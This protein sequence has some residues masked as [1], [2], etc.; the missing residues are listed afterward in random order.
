VAVGQCAGRGGVVL[1]RL[2]GMTSPARV[3]DVRRRAGWLPEQE[4]LEVWL[5][6]HRERV[7]ADERVV[8]HPVLVECQQL[9]D[10]DPVVRMYLHQM[11]EQVPRRRR[12]R[13][14]HLES[15]PE[16]LGLIN[17]A[18]SM[19]PEYGE[20][21][22]ATPL[23]AILD[24]TMGT[25]AGFAAYRDPRINAMLK[26]VLTAWCSF[27]DSRDSLYAQRFAVGMEMR[28]GAP[29]DRDRAVPARSRG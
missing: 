28:R 20:S 29:R 12:Y 4:D 27:L 17:A 3:G 9:I 16:L 5:A 23:G 13:K 14:R 2:P 15:V 21:M 19:A 26:K 6:G 18:L 8:L 24:W 11:I 1:A 7:E 10:S 25:R 22:V